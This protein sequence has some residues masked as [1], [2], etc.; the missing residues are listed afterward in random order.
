MTD[1]CPF[2]VFIE[3]LRYDNS[4]PWLADTLEKA[5][6]ETNS[7]G[8]MNIE[9][10]PKIVEFFFSRRRQKLLSFRHD[11]KRYSHE[12][13]EF[14]FTSSYRSRHKIWKSL[15]NVEKRKQLSPK[16]LK[17]KTKAADFFLVACDAEVE[18]RRIQYTNIPVGSSI[19]QKFQN[20]MDYTSCPVAN[21]ILY[22]ARS[23]SAIVHTEGRPILEGLGRITLA[24][25]EMDLLPQC[26]EKGLVVYI[27]YNLSCMQ[28][29]MEIS[30]KVT[31]TID[32]GQLAQIGKTCI[33]HYSHES[34]EVA[35][36]YR[37]IFFLKLAQL[38]MG[39]DIF[40]QIIPSDH[41]IN[42]HEAK[43]YLEL[44]RSKKELLDRMEL[45]ARMRQ[46][47]VESRIT[48]CEDTN[49]RTAIRKMQRALRLAEQGG[50]KKEICALKFNI[51]YFRNH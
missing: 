13:D 43:T 38:Y 49:N 6:E 5:L 29:N 3:A 7:G 22:L 21:H 39:M 16:L 31:V 45:R 32:K 12:N 35:N 48:H 17:F 28:R 11:L 47:S 14:N 40:C 33:D 37:R 19:L 36:D 34:E 46:L 27:K 15:I 30:N 26:I 9:R 2:S 10:V 44:L 25:Q 23:A 8:N 1:K 24:E 50:F 51:E 42:V 18:R 41:Q 20:I 4:Y